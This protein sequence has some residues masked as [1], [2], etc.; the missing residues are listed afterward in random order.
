MAFTFI[1][2]SGKSQSIGT[3]TKPVN[4]KVKKAIA[5]G[6]VEG[7]TGFYGNV[8]N[9]IPGYK[10]G[11]ELPGQK[12]QHQVESKASDIDLAALGDT[13]DVAPN[14]GTFPSSTQV[15]QFLD[16]LGFPK[17]ERTRR[18]Q[19]GGRFGRGLGSG[20]AG[21]LNPVAAAP[22][23]ATGTLAAEAGKTLGVG[24]RGQDVL[25]TLGS[26]RFKPKA[27][28]AQGRIK[29]PR[30]LE[31]GIHPKEA[32]H[33]TPAHFESQINRVNKEAAEIV[34]DVS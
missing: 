15:S 28:A 11:Q 13:G 24:E 27:P 8:L 2:E 12:A 25:E 23:A 31:K 16:F 22:L 3:P 17:E 4:E 33:I 26:L 9:L 34:K 7:G 32:G 19:I 14:F 21:G 30:I 6:A 1:D 18:E 20:I 29:Q 5:R 10:T